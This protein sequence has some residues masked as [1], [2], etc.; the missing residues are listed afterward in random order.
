MASEFRRYHRGVGDQPA[1]EASRRVS[2]APDGAGLG[3]SPGLRTLIATNLSR[4]QRVRSESPRTR[5]AVAV[6]VMRDAQGR[7][8]VPVTQRAGGLARHAG[9][10]ALPG[11]KLNDGESAESAAIRELHE[12]LGLTVTPDAALGLLDDFETRS[13]FTITPVVMW[14][15]ARAASIVPSQSEVAHIFLLTLEEVRAVVARAARGTSPSFHLAFWWGS[16]YA[17]TA[18]IIYQFREVALAGHS[19]RVADFYQPP[20]T[21]R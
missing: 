18:A 3:F 9:Q 20:F 1:G 5:A 15:E 6:V 11:G 10:M 21:H 17:P 14:S 16:M 19:T 12:E 7:A 8:C 13:G 2:E 4:F